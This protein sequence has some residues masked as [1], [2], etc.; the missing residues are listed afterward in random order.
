M[1]GTCT[2][3]PPLLVVYRGFLRDCLWLQYGPGASYGSHM[4][5]NDTGPMVLCL[6]DS[7]AIA[8]Y[9]ARLDPAVATSGFIWPGISIDEW[10]G[11]AGVHNSSALAAEGYRQARAAWPHN[12]V[13]SWVAGSM[14]DNLVSLLVDGTVDLAVVEG[15]TS[16]RTLGTPTAAA[17]ASM[18]TTKCWRRRG[19]MASSTKRFFASARCTPKAPR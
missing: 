2:R 10:G 7:A 18:A 16:A 1:G 11:N 5:H 17:P 6:N 4:C 13:M 15:Y 8:Y 3:K 9:K 19:S 14:D 12:F